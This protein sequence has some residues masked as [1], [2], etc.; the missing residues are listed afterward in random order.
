MDPKDHV[1]ESYNVVSYAYRADDAE[2]GEQGL[3]LEELASH[4]APGAAVLDLGCGCGIPMARW[5]TAHGYTVT[6]IDLSPVQI[7]RAR[8]LVPNA[9]FCCADFTTLDLPE[10]A[11]DAVV[12]FFAIIHVPIAQ[13]PALFYSMR[14]WLKPDAWL[15]ATVGARAWTGTEDNWLGAGGSMS[16]SHEGTETYLQ[17]LRAAGFTVTWHRF[18]PEGSGGHT[19]LLARASSLG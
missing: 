15:L 12:S 9:Q 7:E 14:R 19:L 1:R 13:Q 5:L 18:I 2:D 11:F 4:L 17:W 3:W 16:W 10:Y 8:H 6:G